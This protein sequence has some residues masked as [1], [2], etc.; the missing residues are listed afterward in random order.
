M[1]L[2]NKALP[3]PPRPFQRLTSYQA[4]FLPIIRNLNPQIYLSN[5]LPPIS[6][7]ILSLSVSFQRFPV[8]LF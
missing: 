7:K 8:I 2:S 5:P 6:S 1:P 3:L 4:S